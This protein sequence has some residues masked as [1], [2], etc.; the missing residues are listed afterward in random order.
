MQP[1]NAADDHLPAPPPVGVK[2]AVRKASDYLQE[3]YSYADVSLPDLR[4]EEVVL[5]E[6]GR[7]W[8]ITFGFTTSERMPVGSGVFRDMMTTQ[9]RREYKVIAIDA[10][11]GEALSMKIR[12][13]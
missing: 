2:E 1:G 11:T 3:L 13:V 8:L 5:S 6:D 12:S 4:L 7:Q 10:Q 9:A